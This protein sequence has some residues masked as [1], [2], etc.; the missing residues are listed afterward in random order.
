MGAYRESSRLFEL[1]LPASI[2]SADVLFPAIGAI[3]FGTPR[4][5]VKRPRLLERDHHH[6]ALVSAMIN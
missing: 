5:V 2:I 6:S 1:S 4:T 3:I